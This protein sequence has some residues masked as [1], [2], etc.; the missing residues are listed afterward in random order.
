MKG[1]YKIYYNDSHVLL[2]S[3][4]RQSNKNFAKV[5]VSEKETNDFFNNPSPLF[6][7]ITNVDVLVVTHQ[8]LELIC[9]LMQSTQLVV[10]GGGIVWN[11]KNELLMIYRRG[12][13]DL[14]K[15]KIELR[16][17]IIEGA[18]REVE[19]E[20]GVKINTVKNEPLLTYH[21]YRLKGTNC[22]KETSWFEMKA[23]SGQHQ[24]TAQTEEDIE[25]VRWVG[26]NDLKKYFEDC[27][28]LIKDL[29][30]PFSV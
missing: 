26:K 13:W 29:I 18:V 5:F 12:K 25:E 28:P 20:T 1:D 14:P 23:L 4:A 8:P 19:E 30:L 10:A 11:E 17:K 2:S 24:L 27:Y 3:H 21:A 7:G 9:K 6:D 16:E 22:L 15:G